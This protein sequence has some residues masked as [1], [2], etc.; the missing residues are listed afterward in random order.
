MTVIAVL[1]ALL[2]P[3]GR[4]AMDS[5]TKAGCLSNLR[6]LGQ[7]IHSYVAENNGLLPV[8]TYN[9]AATE[10]ERW[11]E[12]LDPYLNPNWTA[13]ADAGCRSKS[14]FRC[15]AAKDPP[16]EALFYG[17]NQELMNTRE[18][19]KRAL[20]HFSAI[21]SPAKYVVVSDTLG[22]GWIISSNET[23]LKTVSRVTA[24][25]NGR[26]NFLYADGH[27][28]PFTEPLKGYLA[29][30]GDPFYQS[31]WRARYQP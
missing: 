31:L 24:R 16:S 25:H 18:D 12:A 28:A 9:A 14:V 11:E 22:S 19:T 30:T 21:V 5:A 26:P 29:T 4:V 3:M 17:L 10:M 15:P 20:R 13:W 6:Q 7:A 2:I 27:A 8:N 23:K 1:G